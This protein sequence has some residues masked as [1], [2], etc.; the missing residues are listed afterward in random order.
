MRTTVI[1]NHLL[2]IHNKGTFYEMCLLIINKNKSINLKKYYIYS[3][4]NY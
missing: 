1:Y 2:D 3:S 4:D